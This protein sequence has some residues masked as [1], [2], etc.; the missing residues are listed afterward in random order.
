MKHDKSKSISQL[1]SNIN[2]E[3]PNSL[4]HQG[5]TMSFRAATAWEPSTT[6]LRHGR[7]LLLKEIQQPHNLTV[8]QFASLAGKSPQ[9]IYKDIRAKRLLA[10]SVGSRGQRIPD[11]QLDETKKKLTQALLEAAQDADVWTLFHALIESNS[12]FVGNSPIDMVT[13]GNV[14]VIL[15][16]ILKQLGFHG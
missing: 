10:L 14:E 11:W 1:S 2:Q 5:A 7:T 4:G 13:A 12:D 9:Q 6:Q 15:E 8:A 16:T 3:M